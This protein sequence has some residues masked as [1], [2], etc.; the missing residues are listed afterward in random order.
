MDTETPITTHEFYVPLLGGQRAKVVIDAKP[1]GE[2]VNVSNGKALEVFNQTRP[3]VAVPLQ[4]DRVAGIRRVQ[5][6]DG[7]I[8]PIPSEKVKTDIRLFVDTTPCW[9]PECEA[10]RA[11]YNEELSKLPTDCPACEK[12]ALIRKYLKKLETINTDP[13]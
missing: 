13:T 10:L 5:N 7:S 3:Q 1:D 9:F 2:I 11:A 4:T 8:T 12:G 6:A